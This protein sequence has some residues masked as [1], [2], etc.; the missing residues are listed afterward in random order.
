MGTRAVYL[1]VSQSVSFWLPIDFGRE[2]ARAVYLL[3]SQSF[4]K[5]RVNKLCLQPYRT[6]REAWYLPV[7]AE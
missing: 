4:K 7:S 5:S 1:L 3:V 2:V 6:G